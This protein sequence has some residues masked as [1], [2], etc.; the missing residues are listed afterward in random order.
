MQRD[1]NSRHSFSTGGRINKNIEINATIKN[2][3]DKLKKKE[4]IIKEVNKR[5]LMEYYIDLMNI[6]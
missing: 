5:M 4:N 6:N 2:F 3:I 1:W